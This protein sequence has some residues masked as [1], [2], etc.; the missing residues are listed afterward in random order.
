MLIY[1][2][3]KNTCIIIINM[4]KDLLNNCTL[5]IL[6]KIC[7]FLGIKKYSS[8]KKTEL[9]FLIN[10]HNSIL[11]I[12]RFM[13]KKLSEGALCSISCE[14]IRY[15][16]FSF[17]SGNKFIYYNLIELRN[18][19]I[20]TGNFVDPNTRIVYSDK[21]LLDIDTI[22]KYYLKNLIVKS[23]NKTKEN[24]AKQTQMIESGQQQQQQTIV[25][26]NMNIRLPNSVYKASKSGRLYRRIRESEQHILIFE[27]VLDRICEDIKQLIDEEHDN[28][29]DLLFMINSMYLDEY[30]L[31]FERLMYRSKSHAKY[32]IKK[33]IDN[34]QFLCLKEK[35]YNP[36]QIK[37]CH[38]VIF[39]LYQFGERLEDQADELYSSI[40]QSTSQ[41]TSQST[42]T[43][44]S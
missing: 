24:E 19:L 27:R 22:Y 26:E 18:Y 15:P 28:Y 9:I 7:K 16:C 1:L 40:N 39:C 12:Q 25:L 17:K 21:Q 20:K 6:K 35:N 31:H 34:M 33:N 8:L 42:I 2:R 14:Q 44:T 29:N 36:E 43:I 32:V 13:R 5:N 3:E 11:K 10:K 37:I 4:K 41:S 38:D 23:N 30:K